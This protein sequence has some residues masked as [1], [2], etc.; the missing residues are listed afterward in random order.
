[1][2]FKHPEVLTVICTVV[3]VVIIGTLAK[4][5]MTRWAYRMRGMALALNRRVP[6]CWPWWGAFTNGLVSGILIT[7]LLLTGVVATTPD[8]ICQ[9]QSILK[10][11]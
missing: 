2:T 11:N 6:P 10:K 3:V 7:L 4:A 5:S 9:Q 8:H 1:M